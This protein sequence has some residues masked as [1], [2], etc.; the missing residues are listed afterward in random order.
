MIKNLS[1]RQKLLSLVISPVIGALFFAGLTLS[2]AYDDKMLAE[3]MH[4]LVELSTSG[5]LIVHE[6]QKERGATSGYVGSGGKKFAG[7]LS[8]QRRNTDN[9]LRKVNLAV[10]MN[11]QLRGTHPEIA[12]QI[13]SVINDINTLK[14]LR[15]NVDTLSISASKAS[16]FYTDLNASLLSLSG[17]IAEISTYGELTNK[18]RNYYTF[19]QAKESAGQE[20]AILNIA[21]SNGA[22][23]DGL[24]QKFVTLESFQKAYFKTFYQ[25]ASSEQI[26]EF[27]A[28]AS[29]RTG[30]RVEVIRNT[31]NDKFVS[32]N[33]GVSGEEWYEVSTDRINQL[34]NLEDKLATDVHSIVDSIYESANRTIYLYMTISVLLLVVTVILS[35]YV[36]KLLVGQAL[37]LATTIDAVA[38]SKDLSL[39]VKV[40]ST[41]EL[42]TSARSFNEMLTVVRD[43]LKQIESSS[44][45]LATAAEETSNSVA[46]NAK[47]LERQNLETSQAATATEEMTATVNEIASNT[48]MTAD[49]ASQ[50]AAL[51][52]QGVT[53]VESNAQNMSELN[54]QMSQANNQVLQLRDSSKEINEIVDVIKGVAEQTNLL[55]LNAAIEAA[56]AGEQGRGFAVVADE[57]RTLAKRT[58]ESTQLIEEMV[59]RFQTEADAVSKSIELSFAHVQGSLEQTMSVKDKLEDINASI[60]SITDMC[61]QVATAAEEQVAATNEIAMNIRTIND[62][63]GISSEMG[64]QISQAAQEQTELSSRQ[65]ELVSQFKL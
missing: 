52:N 48:T 44:V 40:E 61:N 1:F 57:V 54:L 64:D 5:S 49:A 29:S 14:Q 27:D 24:Y 8:D 31:A 36:A 9:M 47:S 32:G 17:T 11:D 7:I 46:E 12:G 28:I 2:R 58:Q 42:G 63:A 15:N 41:D 60:D 10:L 23:Q 19:M 34:K 22:F 53:E 18:L 45:Q 13:R 43:M 21:L 35:I 30:S 55:A 50:A 25:F 4:F 62:L 16:S 6:L 33:F 37:E 3:D 59:I 39:R 65:H 51:S 38:S 20:R 26:R 56:R